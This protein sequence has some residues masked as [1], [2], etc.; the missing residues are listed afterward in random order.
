MVDQPVAVVYDDDSLPDRIEYRLHE[1]VFTGQ[2]MHV[3]IDG[4]GIQRIQFGYKFGE[5]LISGHK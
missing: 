5:K 4:T 3:G 1:P 2:Q